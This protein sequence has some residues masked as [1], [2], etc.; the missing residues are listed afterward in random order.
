MLRIER[1]DDPITDTGLHAAFNVFDNALMAE[2]DPTLPARPVTETAAILRA[3]AAARSRTR[4]FA[5]EGDEIV[6][7]ALLDLDL[8]D[9]ANLH[10]GW[11]ELGVL[12]DHRRHGLGTRLVG[13]IGRQAI[14]AE[15]TLAM[16][17]TSSR[18]PAGEAFMRWLGAE[19][20]LVEVVSELLVAD[21]D[22]D[23]MDGWIERGRSLLDRFELYW[24][25]GPWPAGMRDDVVAL[26]HVMNDAPFGELDLNDEVFTVNHVTD[27]EAELADRGIARYT[28]AVRERASDRLVGFTQLFLNPSFPDLGQQGDTGV[29]EEFRGN[30]IGKWLKAEMAK[31]F[32]AEHPEVTRVW[33]GNAHNNA[34]ML[35][36]NHAMGFT[37]HHADT[38]WQIPSAKLAKLA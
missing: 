1:F 26:T 9:T 7:A 14:E 11:F 20:G 15:R 5:M 38:V 8:E 12:P 13:G 25:D 32:V 22:L 28:L 4:W 34:A 16:A 35:A 2:E 6:A 19:A 27:F 17:G 18:V 37:E 36:I 21:L 33:T 10:I 3:R 23:L 30:G 29:F 31:R 24:V